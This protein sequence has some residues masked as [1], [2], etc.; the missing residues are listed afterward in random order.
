[1]DP[2][3]WKGQ[4]SGAHLTPG[5][6]LVVAKTSGSQARIHQGL[7][8]Q[9]KSYAGLPVDKRPAGDP[10]SIP[11]P[12]PLHWARAASPH[13]LCDIMKQALAA[14]LA[15]STDGEPTAGDRHDFLPGSKCGFSGMALE[16]Q[17]DQPE[18]PD[19]GSQDNL[20]PQGP[21]PETANEDENNAKLW[22]M[23][24]DAAFTSV[25]WNDKGDTVVIKADLF[26]TEVLQRRGADRI[27]ETD[28]IKTF[29]W[30]FN[31]NGFR[32]ICPSGHS[33]GKK[34]MMARSGCGGEEGSEELLFSHTT[35]KIYR[36]S[37][38]QRDKPLLLQNIWR[39]VTPKRK[40]QAVATRRSPKFH[41]NESTQEADKKAQKGTPIVHKTPG[42]CSFVFYGLWSMGSVAGRAR[43]NHL[44]SEQGGPSGEGMSSN[45]TS[46]PPA[47]AGRDRAGE[48][49]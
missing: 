35:A 43:E 13:H 47:T 44:P 49:P 4:S 3:F 33:V 10:I 46:V 1:M 6:S 38:F 12:P 23:V 21:N 7:A 39:K 14:Q 36:N 27:F 17:G 2:I 20:L 24:E 5:V 18:S 29:I 30:E 16:K 48:L 8:F 19:P 25:H 42:Q 28:S 41:H 22:V 32:E 31:L 26:Q 15:P 9:Q 34:R 45:A 11:F 40:K 37:K